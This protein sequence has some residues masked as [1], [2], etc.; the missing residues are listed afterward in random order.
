MCPIIQVL[1]QSMSSENI[2]E[3]M[4]IVNGTTNYILTRMTQSGMSYDEALKEATDL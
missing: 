4:G 2:T 3:V 1:K